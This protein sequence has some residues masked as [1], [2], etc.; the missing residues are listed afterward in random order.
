[1]VR[2]MRFYTAFIKDCSVTHDGLS[3]GDVALSPVRSAANVGGR[4]EGDARVLLLLV[5]ELA[6]KHAVCAM[7]PS[8]RASAVRAVSP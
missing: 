1:M 3:L 2:H 6:L 4:V 7:L 8:L 5:R